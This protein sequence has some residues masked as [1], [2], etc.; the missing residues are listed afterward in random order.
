MA[1]PPIFFGPKLPQIILRHQ[2]MSGPRCG[3]S[4]INGRVRKTWKKTHGK[5]HPPSIYSGFIVVLYSG[6]SYLKWWCSRVMLV[7]QRGVSPMVSLKWSSKDFWWIFMMENP[8]RNGYLPFSLEPTN[9]WP[10]TMLLGRFLGAL[11]RNIPGKS[12]RSCSSLYEYLKNL[13]HENL[14]D[15]NPSVTAVPILSIFKTL[16]HGSGKI[17]PNAFW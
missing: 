13:R 16:R 17:N 5:N 7:Y 11:L 12:G 10:W 1:I 3:R 15:W 6:C 4:L 9:Q 14:S 8:P 2:L